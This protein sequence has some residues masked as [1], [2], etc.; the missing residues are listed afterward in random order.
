MILQMIRKKFWKYQYVLPHISV[1]SLT[2]FG[3]CFWSFRLRCRIFLCNIFLRLM[4][5]D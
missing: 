4:K 2:G 1:T 3:Y 5:M